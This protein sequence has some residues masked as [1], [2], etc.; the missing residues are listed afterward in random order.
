MIRLTAAEKRAWRLRD[1][2]P[3]RK[4][5]TSPTQ[6]SLKMLR[7]RGY[8]V[9]VV[10]RWNPH[11]RIRQ[12]A[13]GILDLIAVQGRRTIGVQTTSASNMAARMRKIQESAAYPLLKAAG[14]RVEVHGWRKRSGRW[15]CREEW[16]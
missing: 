14:W 7:E 11:A 2:K 10:E 5:S 6:R 3:V 12:D 15:I 9:A 16:L 8:T 13:F 4:S 1:G